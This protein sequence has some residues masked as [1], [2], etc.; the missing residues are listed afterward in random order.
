MKRP[1]WDTVWGVLGLGALWVGLPV[2]GFLTA[3]DSPP[4]PV[5]Y[6]LPTC[7]AEVSTPCALRDGTVV[8]VLLGAPGRREIITAAEYDRRLGAAFAEE[9]VY[10]CIPGTPGGHC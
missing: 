4:P 5:S 9:A 6:H 10:D 7:S 2:Y 3:D 8:R 1:E